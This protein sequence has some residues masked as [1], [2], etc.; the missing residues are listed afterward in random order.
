MT[1]KQVHRRSTNTHAM[2]N[3][4]VRAV[5]PLTSRDI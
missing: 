1:D 2:H 3:S 5:W 4:R